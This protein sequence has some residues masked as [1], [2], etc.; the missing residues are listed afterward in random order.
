M[1]N[2]SQGDPVRRETVTLGRFVP[3]ILTIASP[4]PLKS[5]PF[6]L[7]GTLLLLSP[8]AKLSAASS[9]KPNVLILL[10]DDMGYG[11]PHCFNPQSK[12]ATPNIDK[13][14]GEG[15]MFTNAHAPASI[16]VPSRYGLL[17]GR[18]PYR[19]WISKGARMQT[20]NGREIM[21]FAAPMLQLSQPA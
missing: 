17:T 9:T 15:M 5:I 3:R 6:I 2:R 16:C 1:A 11:D 12:I 21:H 20:R 18:M 14:A 19:T 8:P 7:A 10:V 13:L 4:P